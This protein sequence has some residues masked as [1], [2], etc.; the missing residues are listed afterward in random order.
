MAKRNCENGWQQLG[1]QPGEIGVI[2]ARRI[3]RAA[4]R[5]S[6]VSLASK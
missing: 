4:W 1:I 3:R 2:S 6:G 5:L